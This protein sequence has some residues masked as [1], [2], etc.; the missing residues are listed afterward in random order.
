[1][2]PIGWQSIERSSYLTNVTGYNFLA[3]AGTKPTAPNVLSRFTAIESRNT[4]ENTN[5]SSI[6]IRTTPSALWLLLSAPPRFAKLERLKKKTPTATIL[7]Q[8]RI[9]LG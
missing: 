7:T 4:Q 6:N 8:I 5:K 2:F 9:A 1:M 3:K